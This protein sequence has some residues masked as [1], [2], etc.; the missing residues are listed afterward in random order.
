MVPGAA[1]R[2]AT[3]CRFRTADGMCA[4]AEEPSL[5]DETYVDPSAVG[6]SAAPPPVAPVAPLAAPAAPLAPPDAST[7]APPTSVPADAP[8]PPASR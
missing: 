6:A 3:L 1:A 2:I 7:A 5:E 4:A 8:P